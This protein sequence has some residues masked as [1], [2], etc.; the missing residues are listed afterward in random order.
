MSN[1]WGAV[2]ND[3]LIAFVP[4]KTKDFSGTIIICRFNLQIYV[5]F[6]RQLFTNHDVE[7]HV[8]GILHADRADLAEILN[9]LFNVLLDDSV[10]L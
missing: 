5:N 8:V 3:V 2:H 4:E 10:M 7:N 6:L 1:F 9:S